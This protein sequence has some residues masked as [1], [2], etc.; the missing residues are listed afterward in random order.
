MVNLSDPDSVRAEPYLDSEANL[1]RISVSPDG[2]L[3]AYVSNES[4]RDE[5]YVRSFPDPGER[6]LV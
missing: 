4:G 5:V 2:A 6:T 3:A 1:H